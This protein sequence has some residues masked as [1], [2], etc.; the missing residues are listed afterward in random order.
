MWT[1]LLLLSFYICF[2]LRG[3]TNTGLFEALLVHEITVNISDIVNLVYSVG[4]TTTAVYLSYLRQ[5]TMAVKIL[6][7]LQRF[8]IS[9]VV[10]TTNVL[11]R[12][13]FCIYYSGSEFPKSYI[14]Q[15]YYGGENF[16]YILQRFRIS[17]V[18]Y[19]TIILWREKF[20]FYYRGS[21]FPAIET[22]TIALW[23]GHI[24]YTIAVQC[25]LRHRIYDGGKPTL[26]KI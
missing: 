7:I 17:E 10:Y 4:F 26:A 15:M 3:W 22:A 20:C 13:K 14:R 24:V 6:Y 9:E 5:I 19:T 11:W 2:S 25:T 8:R 1:F 23:R 16:V 21:E 18:V 12:G